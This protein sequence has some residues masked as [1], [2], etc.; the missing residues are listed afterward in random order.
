MTSV[1]LISLGVPEEHVPVHVASLKAGRF[2][3]V[4]R[5]RPVD[6]IGA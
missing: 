4:T 3:V 6:R 2:L 1:A 5:E